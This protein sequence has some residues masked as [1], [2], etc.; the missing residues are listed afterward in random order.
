METLLEWLSLHADNAHFILFGLLMLAGFSLPVSEELILILGGVLAS[1]VIP[2]NTI[3]LFMAVFLGCYFSDWIAYWLGRG[4]GKR[5]YNVKWLPFSLNEKR[6]ERLKWFYDNYGFWTLFIGRFI[7]FGVRNGIFMTAGIGKM[8]FGKFALSDAIGC[9]VFSAALFS[10]AYSFGKNYDVMRDLLRKGN[11][12]I[13]ALFM[14]AVVSTIL[15]FWLRK[16]PVAS[17]INPV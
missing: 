11:I 6:V 4:L 17:E 14:V 1:S 15:Y 7:P 9:F 12:V 13:F 5:L 10:L 16:K 8:H 2:E 3:H